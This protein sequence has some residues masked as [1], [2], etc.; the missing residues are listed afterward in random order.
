MCLLKTSCQ[1]RMTNPFGDALSALL[2]AEICAALL[3]CNQGPLSGSNIFIDHVIGEEML[4]AGAYLI[5]VRESLCRIASTFDPSLENRMIGFQQC[6]IILSNSVSSITQLLLSQSPEATLHT[7]PRPT[8]AEAWFQTIASLI[9][10]CNTDKFKHCDTSDSI[11]EIIGASLFICVALI[12]TKDL[13]NKVSPPPE[14]QRGM[15]LDGPQTLA[16]M[17]FMSDAILLG[18]GILVST[19]RI[20]ASQFKFEQYAQDA[21]L[22]GSIVAAGLLRAASGALPPWAVELT[23]I[24]FRSL[25][26]AF[27]GDCDNFIRSL[28]LSTKL[29][30]SGEVFAG[31]YFEN[32]SS[33][34]ISSFLSKTREA[35]TKG[36]LIQMEFFT[37]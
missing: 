28:E 33:V 29:E 12:L 26:E 25:F 5:V 32:V 13:G 35:C 36:K 2:N 14:I 23:P 9:S 21:N 27:G 34:H 17:E 20:F 24:I 15:S 37:S 31:R 11:E 4:N 6:L 3:Q 22:G 7:D 19:S 16:M 30:S 18:P 10:V 8:I 1:D